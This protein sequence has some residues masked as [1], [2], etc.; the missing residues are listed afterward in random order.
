MKRHEK[1]LRILA[2]DPAS[3]GF[4]FAV[5]EGADRLVDWGVARVWTRSELEFVARVD[6]AITQ[7]RPTVVAFETIPTDRRRARSARRL[8]ALSKYL[9]D[10]DTQIAPVSPTQLAKTFPPPVVTKRQ[11]AET[12]AVAFPELKA[13]LPRHRRPWMTEDERMHIFDAAAI[14]IAAQA[15]ART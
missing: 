14:A 13:W 3:K 12:I 6:A 1:R 2:I 8:V 9:R 4:G 10:R 11:R 7:Y 15:A 5:V